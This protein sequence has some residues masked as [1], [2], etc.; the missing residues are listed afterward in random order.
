[1]PDENPTETRH[2]DSPSHHTTTSAA[3]T[4][5]FAPGALLAQRYRIITL[6][7]RGGM[8]EV[9]RADDLLVDQTVALK[10][11][12]EAW[13]KDTAF[14]E[15]FRNEVRTARL[16]SH[17]NV[18]RVHDLGETNGLLFLSME[19]IDGEDLSSLLRR[20]G[21]LPEDKGLEIAHKLCAGL[22]AAH[23][24]GV[25]HRDL[26]PANIMIDGR[27]EVLITDFGLAGIAGG[28]RDVSS[29]TPA[30]MAPEQRN[31]KAVTTSSDLYSLGVLLHEVFTGKRPDAS[32]TTGWNP[33]VARVLESCR[34][35]DPELRPR[36]ARDVA[37]A[38]PGGDPLQAALAAGQT[39]SPQA[40]AASGERHVLQPWQALALAVTAPLALFIGGWVADR[41][42]PRNSV[43]PDELRVR[44][45]AM[46]P[47]PANEISGMS[48]DRGASAVRIQSGPGVLWSPHRFWYRTSP[49]PLGG[50]RT[51]SSTSI[52][53]DSPPL[54]V[55]G[56]TLIVLDITGKLIRYERVLD[57]REP[58]NAA[59][60]PWPVFLERT[61]IDAAKLVP[62]GPAS[63]NYRDDAGLEYRIDGVAI[64][65]NVQRFEVR[66]AWEKIEPPSPWPWLIEGALVLAALAIGYRNYRFGRADLRGAGTL[67]AIV[68]LTTLAINLLGGRD[69]L[70]WNARITPIDATGIS[71]LLAVMYGAA[72]FAMEPFLRR[73]WPVIL[74]TWT[75]LLHGNWRD[76]TAG[77][78]ILVGMTATAITLIVNYAGMLLVGANDFQTQEHLQS[79]PAFLAAIVATVY[80][81]VFR[82]VMLTFQLFLLR[83]L[84]RRD[85]LTA[86]AGAAGLAAVIV[87]GAG[88]G[89]WFWAFAG[90]IGIVHVG[91][92]LRYGFLANVASEIVVIASLLV[93]TIDPSAWQANYAYLAIAWVA[94]IAAFGYRTATAAGR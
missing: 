81:G 93:V 8:G 85:W 12:P 60:L 84:L 9:Y 61:G 52:S 91:L 42:S 13:A 66:G 80:I 11:L 29:G 63:W 82:A 4:G 78:D 2:L 51:A 39:P 40:V 94:L 71:V 73:H 25:I 16:V 75:R 46:A 30:Y 35:S 77:R 18:C 58:G 67:A 88:V 3:S 37:R 47:Q 74:V 89:G 41:V 19:F 23:D 54:T 50:L 36:S 26:K 10:F 28:I 32:Q 86:I 49:I 34:H 17:P 90:F 68:L 48:F 62:A 57:P 1:M 7:G 24:K 6:L 69:L 53:P 79:T 21:R 70:H 72:Y 22:Q 55:P 20:I 38:L 87:A 92:V 43:S 33:D 59:P 64:N 65:G 44:A 31:G 5:R 15:R 45:R 83:L 76:P 14:V 56:Q 27:G